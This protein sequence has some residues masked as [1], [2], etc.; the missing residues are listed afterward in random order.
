MLPG[1][2]EADQGPGLV[3]QEREFKHMEAMICGMTIRTAQPGA[4]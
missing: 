2:A 3:K 4:A 1:G